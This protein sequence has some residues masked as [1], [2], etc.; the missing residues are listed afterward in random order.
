MPIL[1]VAGSRQ[2]QSQRGVLLYEDLNLCSW[3]LS[4]EGW[5]VGE[6]SLPQEPFCNKTRAKVPSLISKAQLQTPVF[7]LR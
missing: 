7:R 5:E 1:T 6:G 4:L 3:L 2:Q